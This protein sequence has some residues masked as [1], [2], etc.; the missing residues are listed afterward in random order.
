MSNLCGNS[1]WVDYTLCQ[2]IQFFIHILVGLAKPS[3]DK[4][5]YHFVSVKQ[6]YNVVPPSE[7]RL[8]QTM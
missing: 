2:N 4:L 8:Q 5:N 3:K 7:S 6:D 1:I